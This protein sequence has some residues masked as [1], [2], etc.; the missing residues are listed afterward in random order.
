MF[1]SGQRLTPGEGK[2]IFWVLTILLL[3]LGGTGLVVG[4]QATGD[5]EE[6]AAVLIRYSAWSVA[7]GVVMLAGYFLMRRA[8]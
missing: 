6:A 8:L 2:V 5:D 1:F 7:I 3:G 4:F